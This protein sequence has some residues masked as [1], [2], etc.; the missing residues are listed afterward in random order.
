MTSSN[1][2]A[3]KEKT[4]NEPC[5]L[6]VQASPR[7]KG[8][9]VDL[10][11][12]LLNGARQVADVKIEEIFLPDQ[13]FEFCRGCFSCK[14]SP[15]HCPL[16]D[17]MGKN[18]KGSLHQALEHANG[19]LITLPT[20]LWSANALT[21][22]FFERCYPFLWS[23]QLN[24]MPFG[25]ATSAFN[26]GMHREAARGVEKWA[27]ICG[28][29]QIGGYAVHYSYVDEVKDRLFDLGK[30]VA[31]AAVED[32][33]QGRQTKTPEE[34]YPDTEHMSWDLFELYVDNMTCGTGK[35]EDLLSSVGFQKGWFKYKEAFRFY[36]DADERFRSAMDCMASGQREQALRHLAHAHR[37]WKDGTFIEFIS[38]HE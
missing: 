35:R 28:M 31:E 33:H 14:S 20:Y 8:F 17:D 30:S 11:E 2:S 26:S 6:A 32:F 9:T 1:T 13:R 18:G 21:H 38:R 7:R 5:L 24:G 37:I 10:M 34:R 29:R 4:S 16:K 3:S 36:K 25:Y 19:L 27:F 12:M 15:Y 23:D 22:T